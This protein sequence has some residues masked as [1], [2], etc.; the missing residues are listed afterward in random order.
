MRER[1]GDTD[2]PDE[3]LVAGQ[4][5]VDILDG[6][7]PDG[8]DRESTA[9][10]IVDSSDSWAMLAKG[11]E[12][13]GVFLV[14]G[15]GHP[16]GI[17]VI[18]TGYTVVVAVDTRPIIRARATG[19]DKVGV[20]AEVMSRRSKSQLGQEYVPPKPG[21]RATPRTPIMRPLEYEGRSEGRVLP[22]DGVIFGP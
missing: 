18:Q 19:E 3:V 15:G 10:H 14:M 9:K 5:W 4:H 11:E 12:I 6:Q 7:F 22:F 2:L 21:E 16:C 1:W 8:L 13:R 20:F 17:E